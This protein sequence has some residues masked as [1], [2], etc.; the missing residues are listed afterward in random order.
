MRKETEMKLIATNGTSREPAGWVVDLAG[1][2]SGGSP[3]Y[4]H[5]RHRHCFAWGGVKAP[6]VGAAGTADGAAE[7]A[8]GMLEMFQD[9]NPRGVWEVEEGGVAWASLRPVDAAGRLLLPPDE[10][11]GW[12]LLFAESGDGRTP[13]VVVGW[14]GGAERTA[15]VRPCAGRADGYESLA[16]TE[17]VV[18]RLMGTDDGSEF[19]MRVVPAS[20]SGTGY[21]GEFAVHFVDL[22]PSHCLEGDYSAE[23]LALI[24]RTE[25]MDYRRLAA[26]DSDEEAAAAAREMMGE[27]LEDW[28]IR[29][30]VSDFEP[31]LVGRVRRG[32]SPWRTSNGGG[33]AERPWTADWT[34]PADPG[35]AERDILLYPAQYGLP[36]MAAYTDGSPGWTR[37]EVLGEYSPDVEATVREAAFARF[38][39]VPVAPH[40]PYR[41][42]RARSAVGAGW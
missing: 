27:W 26:A 32:P 4:E 7:A 31:A 41:T 35:E 13:P 38:G 34:G 37:A 40:M 17:E 19:S 30:Q 33:A 36:A 3:F 5:L 12:K 28:S 8:L 11:W 6:G 1:W 9:L 18:R 25:N 10:G 42:P 22:P 23:D 29:D 20:P 39:T 14:D 24:T 15:E 21:T 16:E 2:S